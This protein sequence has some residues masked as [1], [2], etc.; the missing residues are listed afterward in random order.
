MAS[1]RNRDPGYRRKSATSPLVASLLLLALPPIRVLAAEV[2]DLSPLPAGTGGTLPDVLERSVLE[3]TLRWNGIVLGDEVLDD[4]FCLPYY[5]I[6]SQDPPAAAIDELRTLA[7][8]LDWETTAA[9]A[10]QLG[11][12][13]LLHRTLRR[14]HIEV[15]EDIR[16]RLFASHGLNGIRNEAIQAEVLRITRALDKAGIPSVPLKGASLMVTLYPDVA[17]RALSDIDLLVPSRLAR[18]AD[19]I[20]AAAGYTPSEIGLQR[21][22][23]RRY[24]HHVSFDRIG[25]RPGYFRCIVVPPLGC[26]TVQAGDHRNVH[27]LFCVFYKFEILVLTQ[28]HTHLPYVVE[29][30]RVGVGQ[31][32]FFDFSG[33][34]FD[35]L[36]EQGF[37]NYR[38]GAG[39]FAALDIF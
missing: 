11:V 12:A 33:L 18:E 17:L 23:N 28:P 16:L 38:T 2:P 39:I 34:G 19:E 13:P 4:S 26:N 20:L 32:V 35:L 15:P 5:T 7:P 37:Q 24:H 14:A 8:A 9:L 22:R 36:L 6:G 27:R 21:K 29:G 30:F 31:G 25:P 1:H 3:N 10:R